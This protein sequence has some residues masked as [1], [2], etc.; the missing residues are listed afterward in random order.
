MNRIR[1]ALPAVED[2]E[3]IVAY[4]A[5]ESVSAAE[6]FVNQLEKSIERLKNHERIGRLVP[7]LEKHNVSTYREIVISPW[8][9]FYKIEQGTVSI[10]AVI[11]GRRNIQDILLRRLMRE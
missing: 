2:V 7:E 9:I 8:R 4:L 3:D 5:A 6:A 10:L 1:W 11:D